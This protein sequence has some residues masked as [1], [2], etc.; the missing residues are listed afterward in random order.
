MKK[1]EIFIGALSTGIFILIWFAASRIID[2]PFLIP[3][4]ES[5][6]FDFFKLF[7]TPRYSEMLRAT[8][9]RGLASFGISLII[10][11]TL[12][13]G[14]GIS[15]TLAAAVR[16]WMSIVKATPVVSFILIALLWFGSSFVPIFVSVLM[17]V[18][19]MTEAI[20]QG[21]RSSDKKL[22]EMA[23]VYHFSKKNI[24]L[25]IQLPSALPYFLGGAGSSLGL[26]WKVVVAGEILSVPRSGIGSAMQSAKIHLETP[27][28][29]SLTVTAIL[30]SIF[31]GLLF[32]FL[33]YLSVRNTAQDG[34]SR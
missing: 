27:R 1:R 28:V 15:G 26:T 25:H 7:E 3:T 8:C 18:P 29:F 16:P 9:Y 30:L 32:D 6:F 24:L 20:A 2:S 19:I 5:V 13:V 21:V 34:K 17:T 23:K 4:P 10:S 14:S 11:F 31:T 12:G 33:V 22:L